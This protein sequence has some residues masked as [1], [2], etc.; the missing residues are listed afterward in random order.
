MF[1]NRTNIQKIRSEPQQVPER[2]ILKIYYANLL[3]KIYEY[4]F[5]IR[6]KFIIYLYL[7]I[8]LNNKKIINFLFF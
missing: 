4:I 6:L 7:L 3:Y 8:L 2:Y 1:Q 5:Y